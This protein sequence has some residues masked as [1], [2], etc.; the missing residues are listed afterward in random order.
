[1]EIELSK[2]KEEIQELEQKIVKSPE[3]I[4]A[5]TAEKEQELEA[6]RVEKKK[7]E[8]QYMELIR[9]ADHLKEFSKTLMPSLD[10][11]A[12]AFA[13]I[14]TMRTHCEKLYETKLSITKREEQIKTFKV[15]LKE[16]EKS[17]NALKQQILNNEKQFQQ[18]IQT[19][20]QI[21]NGMKKDLEEKTKNQ[22]K[23]QKN[24]LDERLK[25]EARLD[26]LDEEHKQFKEK[27]ETVNKQHIEQ[28]NCLQ[29]AIQEH[30]DEVHNLLEKRNTN[31]F[32]SK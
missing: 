12:Q 6:K 1:M 14:E 26:A 20:K 22:T 3:R 4:Q 23:A 2:S 10:T 25:L 11:F 7:L 19:M 18:Q 9:A 29:R 13:N 27:F 30:F 31:G 17:I 5:D 32:R 8:K 28:V 24:C 15:Q 16:Q 21:N